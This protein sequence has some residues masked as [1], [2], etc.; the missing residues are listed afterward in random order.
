ML[1]H[2][3][4]SKTLITGLKIYMENL[5]PCSMRFIIEDSQ[6]FSIFSP[7]YSGHDLSFSII[8]FLKKTIK[9]AIIALTIHTHTH[10]HQASLYPHLPLYMDAT[11]QHFIGYLHLMPALLLLDYLMS[12]EFFLKKKCVSISLSFRNSIVF[13]QTSCQHCF[14]LS[15]QRKSGEACFVCHSFQ[16]RHAVLQM[17]EVGPVRERHKHRQREREKRRRQ[18]VLHIYIN[19]PKYISVKISNANDVKASI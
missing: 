5:L 19:I 12:R 2:I 13:P 15:V 14:F 1:F 4:V 8:N 16:P 3:Q 9:I 6:V 7:A 18:A 17:C 10:T 11:C